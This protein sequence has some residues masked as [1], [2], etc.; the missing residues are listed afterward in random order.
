MIDKD[1]NHGLKK[2]NNNSI[3]EFIKKMGDIEVVT[4][5]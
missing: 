2:D 1:R 5:F 4:S 3:H